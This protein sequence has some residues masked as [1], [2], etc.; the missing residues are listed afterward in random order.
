MLLLDEL[1][2]YLEESDQ[3]CNL[4]KSRRGQI[5][6]PPHLLSVHALSTFNRSTLLFMNYEQISVLEAVLKAVR[7][8]TAV[9]ALW[10]THRLEEL[11]YADGAAYMENGRVVLS[12]SAADVKKHIQMKRE[13]QKS[14]DALQFWTSPL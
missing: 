9:T 7:G 6:P 5:I 13:F 11:E 3:V 10:V 12:G 14:Q 1:T 4:P 2:T 8:P